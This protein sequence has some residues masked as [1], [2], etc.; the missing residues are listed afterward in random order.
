MFLTCLNMLTAMLSDNVEIGGELHIERLYLFCM[1]WTY[2]GLLE[3]KDRRGFNDLLATLSTACVAMRM[4]VIIMT[5]H[6]VF[7]LQSSG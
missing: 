7:V 2:G 5:S 6:H 3:D 1:M 4:R